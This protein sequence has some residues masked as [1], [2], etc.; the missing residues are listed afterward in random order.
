M[1]K[2]QFQKRKEDFTC[3]NCYLSV[4]GS[5]YT[6]HCPRCL[7]SLHVDVNPGDRS[8]VCR[9]MMKPIGIK[10]EKGVFFLYHRCVKCKKIRRVKT[11]QND[12]VEEI[13]HLAKYS[14]KK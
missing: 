5:G 11:A 1:K 13:I 12:K 9:G 8:E 6:N 2:K 14:V 10:I 3:G 7:W 4:K